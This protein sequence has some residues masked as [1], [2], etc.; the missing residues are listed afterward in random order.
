MRVMCEW[1]VGDRGVDQ[2]R[3]VGEEEDSDC[4]EEAVQGVLV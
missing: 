3:W 1:S 2:G 4:V